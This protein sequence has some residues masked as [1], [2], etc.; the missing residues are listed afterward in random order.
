MAAPK[1]FRKAFYGE[2]DKGAAK[3][4]FCHP[5][6]KQDM[7]EEV[8]KMK[9][10]LDGGDIS[11]EHKMSFELRLKEREGR[12]D[13]INESEERSRK[14]FEEDKDY[15]VKRRNELKETIRDAMPSRTDV[16]ERRV[17][18]HK[19]IKDEKEGGLGQVKTEFI[20]LSRLMGEDSNVSFLQ[21]GR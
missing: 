2:L 20:V 17:N 3:P 8:K 21:R 13:K 19:V 11:S 9:R 18:P 4:T 16:K 7:E 14:N 5:K 15:W 1:S 10:V 12:L 6:R